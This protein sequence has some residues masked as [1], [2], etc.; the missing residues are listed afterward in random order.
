M[1]NVENTKLCEQFLAAALKSIRYEA[2][3]ADGR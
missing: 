1:D 3:L 2:M